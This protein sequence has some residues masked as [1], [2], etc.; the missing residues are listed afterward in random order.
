MD[1]NASWPA[2]SQHCSLTTSPPGKL[3]RRQP[4]STPS[5]GSELARKRWSVRRMSRLDLPAELEPTRICFWINPNGAEEVIGRR[6]EAPTDFPTQRAEQGAQA[7]AVAARGTGSLGTV[8]LL[9]QQTGA[10][11]HGALYFASSTGGTTQVCTGQRSAGGR[12]NSPGLRPCRP[13]TP[14]T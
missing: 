6:R 7:G 5:V 4:N 14:A 2:V 10:V 12:A 11:G 8:A 3:T 9:F 13:S 1:L